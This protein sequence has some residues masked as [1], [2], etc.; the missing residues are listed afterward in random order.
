MLDVIVGMTVYH[1]GQVRNCDSGATMVVGPRLDVRFV[2]VVHSNGVDRCSSGISDLTSICASDLGFRSMCSGPYAWDP[3]VVI[4]AQKVKDACIE[5][6]RQYRA[7]HLPAG[8]L[9]A[10]MSRVGSSHAS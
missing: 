9:L 4:V 2:V 1:I 8:L 6:E 10:S 3:V 5:D 7:P